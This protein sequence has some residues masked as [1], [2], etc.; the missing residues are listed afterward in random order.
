MTPDEHCRKRNATV[1]FAIETGM[2]NDRENGEMEIFLR[3][4]RLKARYEA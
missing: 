3:W 1:H 2:E 4:A